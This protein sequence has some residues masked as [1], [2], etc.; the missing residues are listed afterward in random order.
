MTR[1][2]NNRQKLSRHTALTYGKSPNKLMFG[3]GLNGRLPANLS[4]QTV[5]E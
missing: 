1:D 2:S 3:R 5:Q 4:K